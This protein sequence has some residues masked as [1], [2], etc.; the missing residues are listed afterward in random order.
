MVISLRLIST[1]CEKKGALSLKFS[2]FPRTFH[3]GTFTADTIYIPLPS[4]TAAW[5]FF[6]RSQ[7][8]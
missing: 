1:K 4:K 8:R 2:R 3:S 7:F 6:S 5:L